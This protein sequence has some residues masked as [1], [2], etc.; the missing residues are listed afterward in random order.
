MLSE[1]SE[2][3][4][5]HS[6]QLAM[7]QVTSNLLHDASDFRV[8]HHWQGEKKPR[9]LLVFPER[10]VGFLDQV[11]AGDLVW[12]MLGEERHRNPRP[13]ARDPLF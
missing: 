3:F 7:G 4:V 5:H 10:Q 12:L 6:K 1:A 11:C 13:H 9:L 2:Q 8:T